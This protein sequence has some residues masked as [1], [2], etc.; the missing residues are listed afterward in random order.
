MQFK[1]LFE[2]GQI[3]KLTTRNKLV[4]APMSLGYT[5]YPYNFTR[6]YIDAIEERAKGGVG[7]II[8]AHVKAESAIDPY[9]IGE[10]FACLDREYNLRNF[11]E[12]TEVTRLHGAK[13]AVQLSAGTGRNADLPMSEKWPA[14]PSVVPLRKNPQLST[15][16]LSLDDISR[17][18]E[19]YGK[20]AER[21]KQA[22]FDAIM[23]HCASSYLLGQFL[24]PR[25]NKRTDRYGGS[26]ENRMRFMEECIKSAMNR[27]GS[28]F[29]LLAK[30]TTDHMSEAGPSIEEA[31]LIAKRLEELGIAAMY[32]STGGYDA[33]DWVI[34]PIYYPQGCKVPYTQ[35]VK[36]TLRIPVILDGRIDDPELAERLLEEGKADFI[37][38]GRP[39]LADPEWPKKV[40]EGRTTDIR[41][42]IYCNECTNRIFSCRYAKCTV[43]PALGREKE[44]KVWLASTHKRVMVIGGGP[45]G[46][47]AATIAAIRGHKVT[48]YEKSKKLGGN[49][50]AASSPQFKVPMRP[51]IDWL[52]REANRAGVKI[53]LG[54]EATAKTI[55]EIKPDVVVLATGSIPAIPDVPGVKGQNVATATDILLGKVKVGDKVVV[56]GGGSIGCETALYLA[57]MAKEVV[58]VEMLPDIAL[59]AGPIEKV[60]LLKLLTESKVKWFTGMKLDR[61]TEESAVVC[62]KDGQRQ[63]FQAG[64]VVLATGMK[65]ND[66][67]YKEL[68]GKVP[69]LYKIGDALQP[70]RVFDAIHEGEAVAHLI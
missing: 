68:E 23:V 22:G 46:M 55:E 3:G 10:M 11:A 30:L 43:N 70:R 52:E 39:L 14:A 21:A 8:T 48:L 66:R 47:R 29:P 59:D 61:I 57:Q 2:T 33:I 58:I 38:L 42:C 9:P 25:W 65:A 28:D 54:R 31:K 35:L 12:L 6:Q 32:L 60:A 5:E 27:V 15:R 69:E 1:R 19:A 7:L 62:N 53:E 56:V 13:I 17:L 41:N 50:R 67:L 44:S 63:T 4:M 16:E 49:L 51:I 36:E 37:G 40:K 20:A 26:L 45:G 34:P 64:S 24:N 18:V